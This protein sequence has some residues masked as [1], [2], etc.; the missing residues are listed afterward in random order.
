MVAGYET[1]VEQIVKRLTIAQDPLIL[2][3]LAKEFLSERPAELL[4]EMIAY[5]APRMS[6]ER[7]RLVYQGVIRLAMSGDELPQRV[8]EDVYNVLAARDE[9]HWVRFLLP[10]QAVRAGG[11]STEMPDTQLDEMPLGMRKWKAR[12]QDRSML[13]RL[14]KQDDPAVMAILLDNPKL[15]ELDVVTWAARRPARPE[16]LL[17]IA[18]HRKWGVRRAVQE[19][20]VRNPYTPVHVATAFLPL[21]DL[22]LLR[23]VATE[24]SVHELLRETATRVMEARRP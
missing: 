11:R 22:Q 6:N 14:G 19:A 17:V 2:D 3:R 15:L 7:M 13:L 4:A 8:R 1:R 10:L 9:A 21:F 24:A 12:L 20:I 18:S 16:V 23:K 5:L